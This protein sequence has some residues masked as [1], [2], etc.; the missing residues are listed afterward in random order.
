MNGNDGDPILFMLINIATLPTATTIA[1][2]TKLVDPISSYMAESE[3]SRNGYFA[4]AFAFDINFWIPI[5]ELCWSSKSLLSCPM[6]VSPSP[7]VE[8]QPYTEA[9]PN[10]RTATYYEVCIPPSEFFPTAEHSHTYVRL[11]VGGRAKRPKT[12]KSQLCRLDSLRGLVRCWR[13]L[14]GLQL[15]IPTLL[16]LHFLCLQ[17]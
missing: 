16:C 3:F 4:F 1:T 17:R 11:P 6:H 12:S 9:D 8:E 15:G 2:M 7:P 14:G 13:D 10:S 5:T